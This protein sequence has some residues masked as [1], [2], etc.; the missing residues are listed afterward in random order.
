VAE[1]LHAL[2][3][4]VAVDAGAGRI[5]RVTDYDEYVRQLVRQVLL[6]AHGERIC[7]P[8]F[9]AGL[10]HMV[11]AP[12][13]PGTASM[14]QTIVYQA[15]TTWLATIIRVDDVRTEADREILRVLVLYTVL[16]RGEQRE[17]AIE[18]TL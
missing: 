11:L 13:S 3:Y 2:A 12:N 17:L 1:V 9:G 16:A 7:R 15:L 4:P 10:R 5:A 6:T 18:V 14:A 8:T